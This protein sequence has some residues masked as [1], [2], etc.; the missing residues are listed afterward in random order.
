M[1]KQKV[2]FLWSKSLGIITDIRLKD[3]ISGWHL[4]WNQIGGLQSI[5]TKFS[6][7]GSQRPVSERNTKNSNAEHLWMRKVHAEYIYDCLKANTH[8]SVC[9]AIVPFFCCLLSFL[10]SF[11]CC[12]AF[13]FPEAE[14]FLNEAVLL[15]HLSLYTFIVGSRA[16]PENI[17]PQK[18]YS[19][20]ATC[21]LFSPHPV[22][23]EVQLFS[24]FFFPE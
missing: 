3:H 20:L 22:T 24:F 7:L 5:H 9:W 19:S 23:R 15:L 11:C 10:L 2:T 17:W 4:E 21:T 6:F 12:F 8:P 18:T 1:F 16:Q 14:R 13:F